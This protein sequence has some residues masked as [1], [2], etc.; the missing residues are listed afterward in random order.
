MKHGQVFAECQMSKWIYHAHVKHW[1]TTILIFSDFTKLEINFH[2]NN[3]QLRIW[4]QGKMHYPN[5]QNWY[6]LGKT[7]IQKTQH[8]QY[9]V[10]ATEAWEQLTLKTTTLIMAQRFKLSISTHQITSHILT[11][12][13]GRSYFTPS[14]IRGRYSRLPNS[15]RITKRALSWQM[16][17]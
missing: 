2:R 14:K 15:L 16:G 9:Q 4:N 3:L 5:I 1:T 8:L 12:V 11:R 13:G 7:G 6:N 17:T 10:Y